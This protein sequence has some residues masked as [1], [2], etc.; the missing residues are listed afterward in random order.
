MPAL[1]DFFGS[2]CPSCTKDILQAEPSKNRMPGPER[3]WCPTC[4]SAFTVEQLARR[5]GAGSL[6]RRLFGG[7]P[8]S[9]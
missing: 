9:A 2:D 6:L 7:K 3:A 1:R 4:Q 5:P 8:R